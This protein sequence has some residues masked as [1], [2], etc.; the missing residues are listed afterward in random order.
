[1]KSSPLVSVSTPGGAFI[2]SDGVEATV[3][4]GVAV[5]DVL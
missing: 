2:V 4:T 5:W 3:Q 1:M